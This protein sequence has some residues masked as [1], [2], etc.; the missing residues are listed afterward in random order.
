[1]Q[2]ALGTGEPASVSLFGAIA[3]NKSYLASR[4]THAHMEAKDVTAIIACR[5]LGMM[6]KTHTLMKQ[7]G[8]TSYFYREQR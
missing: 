7:K 5:H 3:Q 8:A 6:Y 2:T 4:T 1:M